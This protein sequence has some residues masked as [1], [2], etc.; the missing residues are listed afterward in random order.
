MMAALG[1]GCTEKAASDQKL[2]DGLY[3]LSDSLTGIK[4][5][6]DTRF[7]ARGYEFVDPRILLPL[8]NARVAVEYDVVVY[9]DSFALVRFGTGEAWRDF[10]RRNAKRTDRKRAGLVMDNA[11][12]QWNDS[13]HLAQQAA[14]TLCYCDHSR[15]EIKVIEK[16][17]KENR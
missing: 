11:L 9:A 12:I 17:T 8:Q 2:A 15:E 7:E 4:V 5:K 1:A 14:I 13:A 16:K 10:W 3:W 6:Y